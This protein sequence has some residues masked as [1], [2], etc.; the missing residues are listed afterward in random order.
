[1]YLILRYDLLLYNSIVIPQRGGASKFLMVCRHIHARFVSNRV[2]RSP[3]CCGRLRMIVFV[4]KY[5]D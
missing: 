1:M 3:E 5:K 2:L 4:S